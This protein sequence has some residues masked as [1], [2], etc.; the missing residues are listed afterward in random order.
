MTGPLW[1]QSRNNLWPSP[2][3][4]IALPVGSPESQV[5]LASGIITLHSEE[6]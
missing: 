5:P 1:P 2:V 3:V 6:N 4:I